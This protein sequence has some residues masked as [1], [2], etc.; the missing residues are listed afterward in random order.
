MFYPN[1]DSDDE[2]EEIVHHHRLSLSTF[3][4]TVQQR[5]HI[6]SKKIERR[7]ISQNPGIFGLYC[8]YQP[9]IYD[10]Y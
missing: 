8:S 5:Q 3:Q 6:S 2:E 10:R 9:Y 4:R 1:N 7:N